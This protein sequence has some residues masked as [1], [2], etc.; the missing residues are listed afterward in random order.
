MMV[1]SRNALGIKVPFRKMRH[2]DSPQRTAGR[3][4]ARTVDDGLT[5]LRRS[6]AL[7]YFGVRLLTL[8]SGAGLGYLCGARHEAR[9]ATI[10][11]PKVR[12]PAVVQE[13]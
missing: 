13:R 5:P 7:R 2:H 3:G 9:T 10:A 8:S 6:R 4:A 1:T 12:N 11:A